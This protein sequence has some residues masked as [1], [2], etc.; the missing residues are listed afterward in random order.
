MSASHA[1]GSWTWS[2]NNT[3]SFIQ[4]GEHTVKGFAAEPGYDLASGVGTVN[5]YYFA[6]Q[7][8]LKEPAPAPYPAAPLRWCL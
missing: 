2:G 1:R 8:A 4:D 6:Y 7:L 5:A 3:V